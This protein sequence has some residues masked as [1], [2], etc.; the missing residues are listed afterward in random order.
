MTSA[1]AISASSQQ[2]QTINVE[3]Q[4]LG[5]DEFLKLLVCQLKQQDPMEPVKNTEFIAQM[6]QLT[7]LENLQN[8]NTKLEYMIGL[9]EL[10]W[11]RGDLS[12]ASSLLGRSIEAVDPESGALIKGKVSGF[13]QREG[14]V[15]LQLD[16]K[17]V[18]LYWVNSV[19][20]AAEGGEDG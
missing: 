8:L 5:K 20:A 14:N 19:S 18:P 11:E 4:N 12:F 6:S 16:G 1:S 9:Q 17:A 15:W 3:S 2:R 13:Y 7:S 10:S